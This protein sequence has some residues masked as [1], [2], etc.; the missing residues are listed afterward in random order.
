PCRSSGLAPCHSGRQ[1]A[2]SE[3]DVTSFAYLAQTPCRYLGVG[4]FHPALRRAISD[5][6]SSARSFLL[7]TSISTMSPSRRSAIG[8]PAAA[9]GETCPTIK[10]W[11]APEKRP[12]VRRATFSA[13]PA[14]TIAAVTASI[15][16][17]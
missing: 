15:S 7:S 2:P 6:L 8:P 3:A 13:R 14:P 11:V 9:S 4:G 10:P 12:S 16:R 5:L 17:I 1:T